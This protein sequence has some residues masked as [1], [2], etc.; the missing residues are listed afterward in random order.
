M[1]VR[2]VLWQSESKERRNVRGIRVNGDVTSCDTLLWSRHAQTK[3][4]CKSTRLTTYIHTMLWPQ[5]KQWYP[6]VYDLLTIIECILFTLKLIQIH[7][8]TENNIYYLFWIDISFSI[9]L[10][11]SMYNR[12]TC[13]NALHFIDEYTFLVS[14]LDSVSIKL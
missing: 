12:Q 9:S 7:S 10:T 13:F 2:S 14:A 11:L 4:L 8:H 5:W 1:I 6:H 3:A